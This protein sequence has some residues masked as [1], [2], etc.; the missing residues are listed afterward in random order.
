[1]KGSKSV[2]SLLLWGGVTLAILF[3]FYSQVVEGFGPK[4][5]YSYYRKN[6]D[7]TCNTTQKVCCST[8]GGPSGTFYSDSSCSASGSSKGSCGS[9]DSSTCS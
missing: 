9:S 8:G 6:S 5:K 2:R 7:G 3:L 1:M 4:V